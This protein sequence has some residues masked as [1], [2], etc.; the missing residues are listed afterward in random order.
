MQARGS[1]KEETVTGFRGVGWG[2]GE[3]A[4]HGRGNGS[5]FRGGKKKI[6]EVKSGALGD[7]STSGGGSVK[8]KKGYHLV[9]TKTKTFNNFGGKDRAGV[10]K[11]KIRAKKGGKLTEQ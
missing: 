5:V 1:K 2:T 9:Y 4:R 10:A 3:F 7:S 11:K 8:K 6:K